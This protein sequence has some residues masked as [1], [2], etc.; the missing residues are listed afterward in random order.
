MTESLT[1][2]QAGVLEVLPHREP[3][4]FVHGV[5]ELVPGKSGR[6]F[7]T[8]PADHPYT[9]GQPHVPAGLIIE[10]MAQLGG[11][12]VLYERR[13]ENLVV[14]FRSV[15]DFTMERTVD[16]GERLDLFAEVGRIRGPFAEVR[17]SASTGGAPVA[18]AT[19]A[20]ALPQGGRR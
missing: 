9:L 16:F 13:D 19:L 10:A 3:F 14:L 17:T 4:L 12:A 1:L 20:F 5:S 7:V 8:V 11:I 2:D 15:K 18:S 6:G